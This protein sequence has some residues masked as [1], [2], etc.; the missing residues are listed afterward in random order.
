MA[1]IFIIFLIVIFLLA[2]L[3]TAAVALHSR[4]DAD[5]AGQFLDENGNHVY[6]NR[7]IIRK[8]E[9]A[10]KNPGVKNLRSFRRLFS[11]K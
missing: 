4:R 2:V 8:E 10:R 11:R 5:D 7:S 1:K 9:F 6:Y 3:V